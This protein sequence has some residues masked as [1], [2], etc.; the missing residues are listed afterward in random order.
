MN[1]SKYA[2]EQVILG[3]LSVTLKENTEQLSEWLVI[4][5]EACIKLIEQSYYLHVDTY[6][7]ELEGKV[8]ECSPSSFISA[9]KDKEQKQHVEERILSNVGSIKRL[10]KMGKLEAVTNAIIQ[11]IMLYIINHKRVNSVVK[12]VCMFAKEIHTKHEGQNLAIIYP[13]ALLPTGNIDNKVIEDYKEHYTELDEFIKWLVAA[14]FASDRREAYLYFLASSSFGKGL[15]F[16]GILK[17]RLGLVTEI[18][19]SDLIKISKSEPVGL[20]ADDMLNSWV[21][22]IN[23][24]GFLPSAVKEL[25]SSIRL[26][27]KHKALTTASVYAKVFCNASDMGLQ[28]FTGTTGVSDELKNRFSF[29]EHKKVITDRPLFNKD[30]KHYINSLANYI[31]DKINKQVEDYR[32]LKEDKATLLADKRLTAFKEKHCISKKYTGE[33][34]QMLADE[35]KEWLIASNRIKGHHK[36]NLYLITQVSRNFEQFIDEN[37]PKHQKNYYIKLE[38]QIVR[39]ASADGKGVK[40]I[41]H[42]GNSR[43]GFLIA[44]DAESKV[45]NADF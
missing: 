37:Y 39:L 43:K 25:E 10:K 3:R 28:A 40:V 1:I 11:E 29:I 24:L 44:K 13:F 45:I 27:P 9:V 22:L 14:R 23:E 38:S 30:K 26:N 4:N 5:Q 31:S 16:S 7:L 8:Q 21:L 34:W 19:E 2:L 15:L 6:Y 41:K 36:D 20:S 12:R 17:D 32:K 35:F 42:K 33:D 18:K